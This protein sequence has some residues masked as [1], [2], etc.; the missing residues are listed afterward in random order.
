MITLLMLLPLPSP[1]YP[2]D[3]GNMCII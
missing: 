3:L 1:S 2:S